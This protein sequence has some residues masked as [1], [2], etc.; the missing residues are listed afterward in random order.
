V[1]LDHPNLND[2]TLGIMASISQNER[3]LISERTKAALQA[4]Y[5]R[6]GE[7]WHET[8][9]TVD[10]KAIAAKGRAKRTQ[11]AVDANKQAFEIIKPLREQK[12]PVSFQK[13]ADLLNAKK[14]QTSKGAYFNASQ[15]K[16]IYDR[17]VITS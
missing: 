8:H 4:K 7:S 6:D 10:I 9:K 3:K 2:L 13:I 11:I 17:G 1:V 5:K 12:E 14:I 16:R 15:V